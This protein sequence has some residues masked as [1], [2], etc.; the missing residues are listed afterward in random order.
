[1]TSMFH[2]LDKHDDVF[3]LGSNDINYFNRKKYLKRNI[4]YFLD[5]FK[6]ARI[7]PKTGKMGGHLAWDSFCK[8]TASRISSYIPDAK[9]IYLVRNPIERIVSHWSWNIANGQPWGSI[10]NSV[11]R[12][13]KLIEMSLY[14]RQVSRYREH[15][16]DDQIKVLFLEGLKANSR[17]YFRE[18]GQ[19]LGVDPDG[20]DFE[21]A[22]TPKNRP[23]SLDE[24]P[25][26]H[27]WNQ[28][29]DTDDSCSLR[30]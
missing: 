17:A 24:I 5:P 10:N 19:F 4:N 2:Q 28:M 3:I 13:P 21:E 25:L 30:G 20:F 11:K 15:F 29:P 8:H 9:I 12:Y 22:T 18:C 16:A 27:L 6:N 7:D 26:S 23:A 14:W 1:M